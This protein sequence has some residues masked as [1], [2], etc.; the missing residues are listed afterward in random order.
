[1]DETTFIYALADPTTGEVRYVGKS[2]NPRRRYSSHTTSFRYQVHKTNWI[3]KLREQELKPTL[4]VLEEV[5]LSLWQE[6]ERFWIA[7]YREHGA[8][9]INETEG[10][11]GFTTLTP[12]H[13]EKVR[14]AMTGR[15]FTPEHR[16]NLAKAQREFAQDAEREAQRRAKI[17]AARTGR[18]ASPE[19]RAKQSAQKKAYN[20]TP[21][22]VAHLEAMR[23]KTPRTQSPESR[24][25]RSEA[26]LAKY[27]SGWDIGEESRAKI[28]KAKK[29]I[30]RSPEVI[31]KISAAQTGKKRGPMSEEHKA[32]ISAATRGKIKPKRGDSHRGKPNTAPR[33]PKCQRFLKGGVFCSRCDV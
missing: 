27:E 23:S 3:K 29:G 24:K 17:A 11:G 30:P 4:L 19:T 8:N 25:K 21:E 7:Y 20:Q 2:N 14:I 13:R 26:M 10:G 15:I 16:A 9:L 5:P 22:G 28:S 18:K 33:C 1:M 31:A 32:K 6:R 12:E